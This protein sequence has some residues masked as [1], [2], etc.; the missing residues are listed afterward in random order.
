[1]I[2]ELF[3]MK[4]NLDKRPG[5]AFHKRCFQKRDLLE[6]MKC[7]TE[8]SGERVFQA[9]ENNVCKGLDIRMCSACS[10]KSQEGGQ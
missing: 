7:I 8:K 3:G 10:K 5:N 4:L 9:Q 1:M 2:T 6:V